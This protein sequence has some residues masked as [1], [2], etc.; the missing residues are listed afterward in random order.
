MQNLRNLKFHSIFK[1]NLMETETLLKYFSH[2]SKYF[3]EQKYN[4][5]INFVYWV[6]NFF[7]FF[8][9]FCIKSSIFL[10]ACYVFNN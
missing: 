8:Y 1:L 10:F 4:S 7:I 9:I 5:K 2:Q 3:E 6:L